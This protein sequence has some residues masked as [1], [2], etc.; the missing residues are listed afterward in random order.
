MPRRK[1]FRKELKDQVRDEMIQEEEN[2]VKQLDD[3]KRIV[4]TEMLES[5][6]NNIGKHLDFCILVFDIS[7]L[8]F[9][10]RKASCPT[11]CS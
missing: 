11:E 9:R 5:V 10:N 8:K 7:L 3:L 4:T 6:R 2:Y 1:S